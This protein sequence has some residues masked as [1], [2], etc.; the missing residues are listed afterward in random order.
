[1]TRDMDTTGADQC[2]HS[3]LL[4]EDDSIREVDENE[5]F[6]PNSDQKAANNVITKSSQHNDSNDFE[7]K[8]NQYC[9]QKFLKITSSL[10]DF[11]QLFP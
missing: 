9:S 3:I 4:A 7:F 6:L 11:I 10:L 2:S 1:M 8:A 5:S